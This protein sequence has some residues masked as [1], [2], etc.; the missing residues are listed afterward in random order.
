MDL[1]DLDLDALALL[2]PEELQRN[3]NLEQ[4]ITLQGLLD[5][6]NDTDLW[7]LSPKQQM[8]EDLSFQVF[9][10]LYG[11]AAGGGKSEWILRHLWML[12]TKYP[13]YKGLIL[14]RTYPELEE[15]IILRSLEIYDTREAAYKV[16][17]RRWV[18][19]NGSIITFRHMEEEKDRFKFKSAAYE[20]IAFDELTSFTFK[21]YDYLKSRCRTT[22][23][24]RAQGVVPHMISATN[25][26]DIGGPWVK[27]Y[28]IDVAP[29]GT[30][31]VDPHDKGQRRRVFVQAKVDDNPH[32]DEDYM[33]TLDSM[34]DEVTRRQLRDGD[35]EAFESRFFT[36]WD[37]DVHVVEP[38]EIPPWWPRERGIDWGYTN[39]FACVWGAWSP[40]GELVIYREMYERQ[41]TPKEQALGVLDLSEGERVGM[42][43][44]DPSCWA[45]TDGASLPINQQWARHGLYAHKALNN[46]VSGWQSVI[47]R[48]TVKRDNDGNAHT[49]LKVFDTCTNFIRT[50]PMLP[51]SEARPEDLNTDAEDHLAD[52]LRYLSVTHG[53]RRNAPEAPISDVDRI[54]RSVDRRHRRDRART[55]GW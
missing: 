6:I 27:G 54:H 11:G 32:I 44:A 43:Y 20:C 14:R 29:M 47:E 5:E 38:F 28:F 24:R 45:I 36:R 35:W 34:A 13:N 23:E 55:R 31:Y 3:L 26:G 19:N 33:L 2:T 17:D 1:L 37:R 41:L 21:M 49:G 15:S 52:A 39:P 40:D 10:L 53:K 46:R 16:G 22:K 4:L 25:P 42:T 12:A 9:E 30:I 7:S 51:R 8:A 18:F 50:V 48:M